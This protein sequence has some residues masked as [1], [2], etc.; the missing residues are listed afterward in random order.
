MQ[1]DGDTQHQHGTQKDH[2]GGVGWGVVERD[3]EAET[4]WG[5]C[6]PWTPLTLMGSQPGQC[7][8][9]WPVPQQRSPPQAAGWLCTRLQQEGP[10]HT[11]G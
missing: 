2:G 6:S 9:P 1:G 3:L 4:Q 10:A 7:V 11:A 5:V 8:L